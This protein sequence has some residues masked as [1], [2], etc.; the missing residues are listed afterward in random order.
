MAKT[1]ALVTAV[2]AL[3]LVQIGA[4][5]ARQADSA[6]AYSAPQLKIG[7]GDLLEV[8]MYDNPNLSGHFRVDSNG[9]IVVP[10]LG[11]VHVA[12]GT[13]EEAATLIANRYVD[14]DILK[15]IDSYATVDIAE[16][17]TQGITVN[18]EVRTPGVYPALGVR[19]LND[20]MA[21]AGGVTQAASSKV[22][23]THRN[24]PDHPITVTY[25]PEALTPE[26]PHVQIFPGDTIMV[27]KAGIIYVLGDV[28]HSG[29]YV[30]E[31]RSTLTV[32]EAMALAGGGEHAAAMNRVQLVRTLKDG[33]RVAITIPVDRI[34]KGQAA[35]VALSDG[36]IL[37]VPTSYEKLVS[38]Q[39]LTTS[40]ALG[41][42]ILLYKVALH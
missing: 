28:A 29:G 30:L 6:T 17:A 7:S 41:S 1:K 26:I 40:L 4:G 15:P 36:D 38:E 34:F 19:M 22:I 21:A 13:A 14:A 37:Y 8:T 23:I 32:E 11:H 33:S 42:S 24:D 25:N 5:Q 39:A 35:D 9:D 10:L 31:G 16:Y 20:V 2:L 18:G 3:L 27:P 12:G